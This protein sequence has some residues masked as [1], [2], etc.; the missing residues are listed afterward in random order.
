[1]STIVLDGTNYIGNGITN[2]VNLW[3][4]RSSGIV[5]G[6][7]DLTASVNITKTKV[8]VLSKIREPILQEG[9]S[10]CACEGTVLR[11]NYLD[12]N[13]RFDASA[14]QE[15]RDTMWQKAKDWVNSAQFAALVKDLNP[16]TVNPV[17]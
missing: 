2:G 1:M 15:E 11:T 6:F 5:A 14:T 3:Q 4:D 10:A 13:V 9:D 12:V 16:N 17:V 8:N 7:S